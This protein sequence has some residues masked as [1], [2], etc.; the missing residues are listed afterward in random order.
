MIDKIILH[1]ILLLKMPPQ[2]VRVPVRV[3]KPW[4]K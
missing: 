3:K 4:E 1:L 2:Q